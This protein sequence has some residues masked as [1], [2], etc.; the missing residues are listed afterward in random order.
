[1]EALLMERLSDDAVQKAPSLRIG[2]VAKRSGLSVKT[3]RFYCDQGLLNTLRS[4]GGYRVFSGESLAELEIIK[5]LRSMDVPI[6]ELA[7]ILEVRR[8]GVC[9]CLVLKDS[10]ATKLASI[11]ARLEE[12][13]AMKAE[14]GCLLT[15]WQECGG[16]KPGE[17]A[18]D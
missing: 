10:I 13:Q 9:N 16:I 15:S 6:A 2:E 4:N 11:D 18:G 12:L 7:R 14:L 8:A 17:A 1:M 5:A 3:V